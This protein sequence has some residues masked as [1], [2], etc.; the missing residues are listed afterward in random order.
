[1][2]NS[3]NSCPSV[4]L[5]LRKVSLVLQHYI[6]I[7]ISP[8]TTHAFFKFEALVFRKQKFPLIYHSYSL[9]ILNSFGI[10][11]TQVSVS[12]VDNTEF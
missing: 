7:N 8:R 11:N 9:V 4:L 6:I 5:F 1:M 10:E 3:R 2:P 12:S